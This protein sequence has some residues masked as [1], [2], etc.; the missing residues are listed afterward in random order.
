[1]PAMTTPVSLA[2]VQVA[3]ADFLQS[4]ENKDFN[5]DRVKVNYHLAL[6]LKSKLTQVVSSHEE[7]STAFSLRLRLSYN[8]EHR[9]VYSALI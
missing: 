2:T 6:E 7:I 5:E 3:D 9:C 1:M 8:Q 4:A